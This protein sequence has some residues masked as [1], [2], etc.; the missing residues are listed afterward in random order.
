MERA[1]RVNDLTHPASNGSTHFPTFIRGTSVCEFL[2]DVRLSRNT[3]FFLA[4]GAFST[5]SSARKVA[6]RVAGQIYFNRDR[7]FAEHRGQDHPIPEIRSSQRT[8]QLAFLGKTTALHP[9][10][11]RLIRWKSIFHQ[12]GYLNGIRDSKRLCELFLSMRR[13]S[14][15]YGS[16]VECRE[17]NSFLLQ[18]RS[19][20]LVV[21]LNLSI[22]S[23]SLRIEMIKDV[24]EHFPKVIFA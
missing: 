18:Y 9:S 15:R 5:M 24:R 12:H 8:N 3:L 2:L 7:Y 16:H 11:H 20:N 22:L 14:F 1:I 21:V 10:N 4:S 17:N 19:I 23:C 6:R 13:T